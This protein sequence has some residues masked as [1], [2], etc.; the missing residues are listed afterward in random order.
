MPLYE[1]ECKKC[2][3]PF[4]KVMSIREMETGQVECPRCGSDDVLKLISSGGIKIGIGGYA[5]KVK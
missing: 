3:R 1:F 2:R 4:D 5:G